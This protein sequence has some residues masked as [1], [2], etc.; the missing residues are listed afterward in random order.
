MHVVYVSFHVLETTTVRM[1]Y[2]VWN[3]IRRLQLSVLVYLG[4]T[5]LFVDV[6]SVVPAR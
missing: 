2:I 5:A 1:F 4:N 3:T 6:T